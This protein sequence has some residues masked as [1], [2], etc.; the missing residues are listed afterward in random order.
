M[1]ERSKWHECLEMSRKDFRGSG[2]CR[3]R[4]QDKSPGGHIRVPNGTPFKVRVPGPQGR[5]DYSN[6]RSGRRGTS[7]VRGIDW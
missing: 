6:G 1:S 4:L 3:W 7:Q 2:G 5:D